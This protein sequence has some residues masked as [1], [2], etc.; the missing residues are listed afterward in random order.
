MNLKAS[1]ASRRKNP[2]TFPSLP[3]KTVLCK[4]SKFYF[5]RLKSVFLEKT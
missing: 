4:N 3:F 1:Y 2:T 5:Q